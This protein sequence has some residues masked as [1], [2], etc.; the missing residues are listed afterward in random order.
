MYPRIDQ[1]KTAVFCTRIIAFNKSFV[2]IGKQ[3]EPR[4]CFA[5]VWN[6][7]VSGRNQEEI[8]S[9]FQALLIHKRDAK[10][11][12]LWLDSCAAQNKNWTLLSSQVQIGNS[13]LIAAES[14]TL[15]YFETGHTFMSADSF[16]HQV[17]MSLKRMNMHDFRE[18]VDCVRSANLT[19]NC[20]KVMDFSDF[21]D[22]LYYTSQ[23]K[24]RKNDPRIYLKDMV[25]SRERSSHIKI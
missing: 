2:P 3:N 20:V 7:T 1:Y 24:L 4:V 15:K 17:E 16:H 13:C 8:I 12:K 6:E 18:F 21:I 9:T 14:I 25:A 5:A 22:Y 19:R 11:V 10:N 23:H